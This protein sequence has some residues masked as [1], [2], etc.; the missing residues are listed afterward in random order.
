MLAKPRVPNIQ[1]KTVDAFAR[2]AVN[3]NDERTDR[4][5]WVDTIWPTCPPPLFQ[6]KLWTGLTFATRRSATLPQSQLKLGRLKQRIR[7]ILKQ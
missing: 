6:R 3:A 5:V 7:H 4:R 1:I 2:V